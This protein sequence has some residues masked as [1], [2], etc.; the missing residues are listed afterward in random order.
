MLA[1]LGCWGFRRVEAG[2]GFGRWVWEGLFG[3]GGLY[4]C[5][6]VYDVDEEKVMN[7]NVM[8]IYAP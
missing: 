2:W 3:G 7:R 1:G 8:S 4:I 5:G 6:Y